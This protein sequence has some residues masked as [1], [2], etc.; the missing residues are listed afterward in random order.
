MRPLF[1]FLFDQNTMRHLFFVQ[2]KHKNA[3]ILILT[4][5]KMNEA[6]FFLFKSEKKRDEG[7]LKQMREGLRNNLLFFSLR[8]N[9]IETIGS[10]CGGSGER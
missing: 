2:F 7:H 9:I 5:E 8:Y 6:T 4:F 1:Y 10:H 3:D